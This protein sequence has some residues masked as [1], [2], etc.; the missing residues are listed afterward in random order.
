MKDEKLQIILFTVDETPYACWDWELSQKNIEFLEGID[1]DYF[2]YVAESNSDN[3]GD[4]DKHRAALS[5]RIAYSQALEVL[6][7]L[8]CAAAQAPNCVVGWMLAYKNSELRNVVRKITN[9]QRINSRLKGDPITWE[10]IAK[11]VHSHLT[12]DAKKVEWIQSGFG[13]LWVRFAKDFLD[14]KFTREYNS[15]KHG[16]RTKLGGFSLAI[17]LQD[18]PG[19]S[20][21]SEKMLNLGGS[22]YGTSYF[23]YEKI[24]EKDRINFRPR[25]HSR[26]WHPENLI[27]GLHL[28]SVS[29]NN[30]LSFLRIVNKVEVSKCKFLTPATEDFYKYPWIK[31]AG[32]IDFS[33]DRIIKPEYVNPATKDQIL[34]SYSKRDN[35]KI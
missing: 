18:V 34:K 13:K 4:E 8:L 6:F 21:P 17:G 20:A 25:R 35:T 28:L 5:L 11:Y 33:A 27:N 32:A 14:E 2:R 7:S 23:S 29:I 3:L 15:A 12:Y 16:L 1:S 10:L 9:I 30:V 19:K 31:S 22:K 24:S 26:N